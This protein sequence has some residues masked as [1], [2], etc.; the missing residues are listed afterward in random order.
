[1]THFDEISKKKNLFS[2]KQFGFELEDFQSHDIVGTVKERL[3]L[4]ESII[5]EAKD[6]IEA[7]NVLKNIVKE[8][9]EEAKQKIEAHKAH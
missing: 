8:A 3:K 9:R 1:M 4:K 7:K 6:F 2:A 5:S